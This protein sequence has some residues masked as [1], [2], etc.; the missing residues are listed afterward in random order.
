[1]GTASSKPYTACAPSGSDRPGRTSMN[2]CDISRGVRQAQAAEQ[3]RPDTSRLIRTE[4]RAK[5][6]KQAGAVPT[7]STAAGAKPLVDVVPQH[8]P[9]GARAGTGQL[10]L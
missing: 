9:C 2:A 5:R 10:L 3:Q 1:I 6:P 8:N 4:R 7:R